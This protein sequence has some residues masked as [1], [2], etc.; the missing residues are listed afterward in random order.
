MKVLPRLVLAVLLAWP[1][2][3]CQSRKETAA[4]EEDMEQYELVTRT[5]SILPRKVKKGKKASDDPAY[6]EESAAY[7]ERMQREQIRR[8]LG[9]RTSLQP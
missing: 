6:R 9:T 7:L 2:A 1:I 5:G 8:G 3:G 4:Q